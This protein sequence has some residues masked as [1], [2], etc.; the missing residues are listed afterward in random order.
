MA[1]KKKPTL[2]AHDLRGLKYF[3]AL[4]PL[5]ERLHAVGTER[6]KAGNRQL[7]YDQYAALILLYFFNPI[8]TSLR[9]IQQASGL[10]KV[11]RRLGGQ[12]ASLGALSEAARVFAATALQEIISELAGRVPPA[13]TPAEQLA[14]KDLTA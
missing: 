11:Q 7:F 9:A 2:R 12:A 10:D 8:L 4:N 13:T 1:A 14:L 6:D 5:L 3:T